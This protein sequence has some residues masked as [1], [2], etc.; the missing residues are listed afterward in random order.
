MRLKTVQKSPGVIFAHSLLGY[1]VFGF[2]ALMGT[3]AEVETLLAG[4]LPSGWALL[5]GHLGV[6]SLESR[7]SVRASR[8]AEV[9]GVVGAARAT[10]RIA[11]SIVNAFMMRFDKVV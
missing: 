9:T 4:S 6:R 3:R 1:A 10:A 11:G 7:P 8:G 5:A 2:F